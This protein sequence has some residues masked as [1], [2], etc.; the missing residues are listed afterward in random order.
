MN[1]NAEETNSEHALFAV[2]RLATSWAVLLIRQQV[3]ED[4]LFDTESGWS[5]PG[6][7]SGQIAQHLLNFALLGPFATGLALGWL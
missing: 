7:A 5:N 3:R 6:E 1:I 2:N 4:V